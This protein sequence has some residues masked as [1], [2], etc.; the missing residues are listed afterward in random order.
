MFSLELGCRFSVFERRFGFSF[1]R[2]F[3]CSFV[4]SFVFVNV[5]FNVNVNDKIESVLDRKVL[6]KCFNW[7]VSDSYKHLGEWLSYRWMAFSDSKQ[8]PR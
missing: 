6:R 7:R 5:N 1:V 8:A 3:V 2:S 4:R